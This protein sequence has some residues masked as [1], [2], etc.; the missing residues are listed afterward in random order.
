LVLR[1]RIM[2]L[3]IK[4]RTLGYLEDLLDREL[5]VNV[6]ATSVLDL[7]MELAKLKGFKPSEILDSLRDEDY[8]LLLNGRSVNYD[9][10]KKTKLRSGDVVVFMPV[11][12]GG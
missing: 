5:E 1:L 6:N 9:M 7:I 2:G 10:L 4:I 3:Q 11:V 12:S 8:L